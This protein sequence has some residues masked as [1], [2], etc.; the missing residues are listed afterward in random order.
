[1]GPTRAAD[2]GAIGR[3]SAGA[4]VAWMAV[5]GRPALVAWPGGRRRPRP[6][7]LL[8]HGL[9]GGPQSMADWLL[10][11]AL[12]G[13][14]AVALRAAYAEG[15]P[16]LR[17]RLAERFLETL[18]AAVM[19]TARATVEAL[20]A[21]DGWRGADPSRVALVGVSAGGFAVLRAALSS[22]AAAVAC[23]CSGPGW[24]TAPA[25]LGAEV[26]AELGFHPPSL[27]APTPFDPE[28]YPGLHARWVLGRAQAL[29]GRAVLLCVG[30]R[31]PVV[32]V[33][34]ARALHRELVAHDPE[35][36]EGGRLQ[37]LV[38]PAVGH[39]VIAP[40]KQRVVAWLRW[41]LGL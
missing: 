31:D 33:E 25:Q 7:V 4:G 36:A 30:G 40:M 27:Q 23:V 38:Y 18:D 10:E 8:V 39:R 6:V 9:L 1:M 24:L 2:N 37:L 20:A 12:Q 41:M 16:G 19:Q 5:G 21:L 17:A 13:C 14:V 22:S 32:P 26:E 35:G 11:L 28:H 34:P 3:P 15:E 29:A